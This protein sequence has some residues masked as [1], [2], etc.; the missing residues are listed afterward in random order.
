MTTVIAINKTDADH[1]TCVTAEMQTLGAPTIRCIRDDVQGVVLALEGSHRLAAAEALDIVPN[2]VVLGDDDLITCEEIGFDD[3]GYFDG[4]I[5]RA[6]DIRDYI[7]GSQG[8]YA[9]TGAWLQFDI[10]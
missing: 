10:A 1:L 8:T 7:A 5:A 4:E 2:F 6:A 3:N 9:G